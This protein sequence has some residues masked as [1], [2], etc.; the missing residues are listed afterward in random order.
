M[1]ARA[2]LACIGVETPEEVEQPA[3]G[4]KAKE[5]AWGG[6]RALDEGREVVPGGGA[7][8]KRVDIV[9]VRWKKA[10]KPSKTRSNRGHASGGL[11]GLLGG[12][13][14]KGGARGRTVRE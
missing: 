10:R 9:E 1:S 8:V 3:S 4:G 11:S 2:S 14:T 12:R 6:G 5:A 7:G 13:G